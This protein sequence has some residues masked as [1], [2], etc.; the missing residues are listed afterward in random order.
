MKE[1]FREYYL[2]SEEI[3]MKQLVDNFVG[4]M[5]K[6]DEVLEKIPGKTG[7]KIGVVAGVVA[8]TSPLAAGLAMGAAGAYGAYKLAKYAKEHEDGVIDTEVVHPSQNDA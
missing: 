7:V 4:S 6:V 2:E 8:M 3:H 1:N 5:E